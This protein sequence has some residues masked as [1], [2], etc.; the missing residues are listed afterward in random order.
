MMY[1]PT[2]KK[3]TVAAIG[4]MTVAIKAQRALAS[5]GIA[6]EVIAL[7]PEQT[8]RGCAYGIE[9]F[10]ADERTVRVALAAVRIQPSQ[11]ISKG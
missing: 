3:K 5:E 10:E 8:R 7:S 6:A 1:Y 9:F 11:F 4:A 2:Q